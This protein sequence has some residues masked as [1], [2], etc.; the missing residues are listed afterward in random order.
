MTELGKLTAGVEATGLSTFKRDMASASDAMGKSARNMQKSGRLMGGS[1]KETSENMAGIGKKMS[2]FVTA[3][4]VAGFAVGAKGANDLNLKLREVNTLTG[5]TGKE[6]DRSF[7]QFGKGVREVSRE[8]GKTQLEV[9]EGLYQALSAGVPRENVFEFMRV[10]SKAAVGG[11][12]DTNTAVDGLTTVMNA[13]KKQNI[14][15]TD[16][17]D[18]MFTT[19][20]L[21][22]TTFGELSQ[23]IGKAAP[24]VAA[25]GVS[26]TDMAAATA[27]L[28]TK[29]TNTRETMTQ[30]KAAM[31][32]V[33]KPTKELKDAYKR[34]GVDGWDQLLKREGSM[35][36][37]FA[38]ITDS[39][40]GNKEELIK[41]LSSIEAAS[42]ALSITGDNAAD[43]GA[44]LRAMGERAGAAGAAFVEIDKGRGLERFKT[45]LN[46]LSIA[47]GQNVLPVLLPISDKISSLAAGFGD[48]DPK[49]QAM[50]IGFAAVAAAVG[51]ILMGIGMLVPAF[52]ALQAAMGPIGWVML[53]VGFIGAGVAA[54]T[55]LGNVNNAALALDNAKNSVA[56]L[57]SALGALEGS[58]L[59]VTG[60]Q[61]QS[62]AATAALV[63]AQK[64]YREA[65]SDSGRGSAE[66][67]AAYEAVTAAKLADEQAT[68]GIKTAQEGVESAQKRGSEQLQQSSKD[69]EQLGVDIK[70][71]EADIKKWKEQMASGFNDSE[72]LDELRTK[73]SEAESSLSELHTEAGN[74]TKEMDG[75]AEHS[76]LAG[77]SMVLAMQMAAKATASPT[78]K[79]F[80]MARQ[81]DRVSGDHTIRF[82]ISSTGSIP[83]PAGMAT[84]GPVRGAGTGT[85]DSI[86]A[87]LSDGEFV[88]NAKAARRN[89]TLLSAI[90]G[91]RVQ[92][93]ARGGR[94]TKKEKREKAQSRAINKWHQF[95]EARSGRYNKID[96]ELSRAEGTESPLDNIKALSKMQAW[97]RASMNKAKKWKPGKGQLWSRG[98][99]NQRIGYIA[100]RQRDLNRYGAEIKSLKS[101]AAD[102]LADL[103]AS[104]RQGYA[105]ID[106]ALAQAEGTKDTADDRKA[107]G[108][109]IAYKKGSIAAAKRLKLTGNEA[110]SARLEYIAQ[111]ERDINGANRTLEGFDGTG[112]SGEAVGVG[113]TNMLG[114]LMQRQT[115]D[116]AGGAQSAQAQG[117]GGSGGGV[118]FSPDATLHPVFFDGSQ[119][120][121]L[122]YYSTGVGVR[123][124]RVLGW[125][126]GEE[127]RVHS[128]LL[129]G[130][131]GETAR[132][133]L[134]GGATV[135]IEGVV[136][137]ST[138]ADFLSKRK[139]LKAMLQPSSAEA[140]LKMPD[141]T[142]GITPSTV[143]GESMSGYLRRSC[144]VVESVK[145]GDSHGVHGCKWM[146]TLRAS[147][148]RRFDDVAKTAAG[149]SITTESGVAYPKAYPAEYGSGALAASTEAVN[150]GDYA[151]PAVVTISGPAT[152]PFI[153]EL[154]GS[155]YLKFD[156][157]GGLVIPSGDEL[158]IDLKER[159][160]LLNGDSNSSRLQYLDFDTASWFMLEPGTSTVRLGGYSIVA[161]ATISVEFRDAYL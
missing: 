53:T 24:M 81:I 121:D 69:Y 21:G 45:S 17:A 123:V 36:G 83:K 119:L 122:D 8:I 65:V 80:E 37:A 5:I 103:T 29:G 72:G 107:L 14:S 148:P 44:H 145:W 49:V 58:E 106:L 100:Q 117:T 137:G 98:L 97:A 102:P 87:M 10:A 156:G 128:E 138:Y 112:A 126:E 125:D 3:P 31:Q 59:A 141:P 110:N 158:V 27:T 136:V 63:K 16:A 71:T 26:F 34:I 85:S 155:G 75:L 84:G 94:V 157:N 113:D 13:F 20:K 104:R 74:I 96:L 15:A 118:G 109:S 40:K 19:V 93:F 6:A 79:I 147:D 38:S 99:R 33:L 111:L 66:A 73:I 77:D 54:G 146:C 47:I 41:M 89:A 133:L 143:F 139:A 70:K 7:R 32:A 50:V 9:S 22:K 12:T 159:T 114:P 153:E 116:G 48:L 62:R 127:A 95:S 160:A 151:T 161:P 82:K 60:A 4:I 51:P 91:G 90:N 35:Q 1:L 67:K 150:D 23:G 78:Q 130:I 57:S 86:P 131:D 108:Q 2:M 25:A 92:G 28:T 39:A 140:I 142:S 144:R 152:N 30:I 132:E 61:L 135:T 105:G 134:M 154:G 101:S 43:A 124:H 115:G 11:V 56:G 52:I 55:M 64:Q 120:N 42:F 88:V 68:L 129:A 149:S 46:D 76:A 18:T